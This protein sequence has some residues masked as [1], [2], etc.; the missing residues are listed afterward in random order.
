M[1]GSIGSACGE[2]PNQP[3]ETV[4]WTS[5]LGC[6]EAISRSV[7]AMDSEDEGVAQDCWLFPSF[8]DHMVTN[9]R[10]DFLAVEKG[11]HYEDDKARIGVIEY[12]LLGHRAGA[13]ERNRLSWAQ[14]NS[15][16]IS[17]QHESGA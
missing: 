14:S 15:A 4:S 12:P 1:P 6:V 16:Q 8:G 13:L 9:C 5:H 3:F 11:Q 17:L 2:A 10:R 7:S